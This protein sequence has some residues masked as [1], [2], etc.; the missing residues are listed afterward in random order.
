MSYYTVLF[1]FEIFCRALGSEQHC[2]LYRGVFF[3]PLINESC[4]IDV[5]R[6]FE[7]HSVRLLRKADMF[8]LSPGVDRTLRAERA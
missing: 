3:T 8:S 4:K 1:R 7:S 5:A 2:T 6:A